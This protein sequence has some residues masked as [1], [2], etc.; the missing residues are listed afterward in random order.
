MNHQ[1]LEVNILYLKLTKPY[2]KGVLTWKYMKFNNLLTS[3][4]STST[5]FS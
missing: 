4:A 5:V 3:G 2:M 1:Q